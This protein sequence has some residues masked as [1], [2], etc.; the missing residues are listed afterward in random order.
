LDGFAEYL[1][2]YGDTQN[3]T[4]SGAVIPIALGSYQPGVFKKIVISLA[5]SRWE[6]IYPWPDTSHFA[7]FFDPSARTYN[8]V[9]LVVNSY[10]LTIPGSFS[11]PVDNVKFTTKNPMVP[12]NGKGGISVLEDGSFLVEGVAEHLGVF[13]QNLVFP[14]D[15]WAPGDFKLTAANGD[16]L[17]GSVHYAGLE[18]GFRIEKG[19]GR[20]LGAVGSYRGAISNPESPTPLVIFDGAISSVGWNRK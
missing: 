1:W 19:T 16:T 9:T 20:F 15:V 10:C 17:S 14:P 8:N 18:V 5:D 6:Q 12:F 13:K 7:P 3:G 2:N 11:V 4:Y